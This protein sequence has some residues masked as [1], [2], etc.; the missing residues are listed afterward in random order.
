MNVRGTYG[1][2]ADSIPTSVPIRGYVRVSVARKHA[3]SQVQ[4]TLVP[5]E[6]GIWSLGL[7]VAG[8]GDLYVDGELVVENS[9]D[10]VADVSFVS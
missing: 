6:T 9:R 8:Q 1:I 7:T 2:F 4:T 10:Q 3:D 5:D